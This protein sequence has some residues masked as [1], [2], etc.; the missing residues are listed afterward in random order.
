M[1]YMSPNA[2][3]VG[4]IVSIYSARGNAL[5]LLLAVGRPIHFRVSEQLHWLVSLLLWALS[6][7]WQLS[8]LACS[9]PVG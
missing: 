8:M 7:R 6:S 5:A 9:S 1:R 4:A 2:S 3:V